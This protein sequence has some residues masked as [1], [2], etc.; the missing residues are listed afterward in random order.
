[1]ST[2]EER[3]YITATPFKPFTI[4]MADGRRVPVRGRDYILLPPGAWTGLVVLP[5][6]YSWVETAQIRDISYE[7]TADNIPEVK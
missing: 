7:I 2:D 1:M 5:D 4:N 3:E 6:G